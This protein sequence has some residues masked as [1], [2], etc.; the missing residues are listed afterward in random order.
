MFR[1]G[2]KDS[3]FEAITNMLWENSGEKYD[4]EEYDTDGDL[5]YQP[6]PLDEVWLSEP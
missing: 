6:P 1:N 4:E 3:V 5:V 2:D